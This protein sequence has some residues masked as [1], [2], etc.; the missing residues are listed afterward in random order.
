MQLNQILKQFNSN[1]QTCLFSATLP[2]ALAEFTRAGLKEPDLIR[3]DVDNKLSEH[4]Q[5]KF[6]NIRK[7]EKPAALLFLLQQVID[8]NKEQTIIFA[9]TKHHVEYLYQLLSKLHM[10]VTLIYGQL[11]AS[12]RKINIAKF[13]KKLCSILIVTDVA[14]R[15]IDIPLLDN[16]IHYD[17]PAKAKLF[18]HR[19][20]RV[21]RAGRAGISYSLIAND[22]LPYMLD[23]FLFLS[24]P[25]QNK[26]KKDLTYNEHK[27]QT[28]YGTIPRYILDINLDD[29]QAVHAQ[30]N[31][32]LKQYQTSLRAYKMY[33]K[34][35]S[36]ASRSSASR[37]KELSTDLIHPDFLYHSKYKLKGGQERL[38]LNLTGRNKMLKN[39]SQYD[40]KKT[41]FETLEKKLTQGNDIM[42]YKRLVHS[43]VI[44]QYD[45]DLQHQAQGAG[46]GNYLS[47]INQKL[48]NRFSTTDS[49]SKT[50]IHKKKLINKHIH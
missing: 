19:S 27:P 21:A 14:A 9:S 23:L 1:R 2:K 3:L 35:R 44:D 29:I 25:V 46:T 32:L 11:D 16:V 49:S 28:Y 40:G 47:Q 42:R 6:F 15:G 7:E 34:T 50:L 30:D 48:K 17:F 10:K 36:G 24:F 45:K 33:Y 5:C 8:I 26:V 43:H 12:A 37:A 31:I 38:Q 22:E 20:G 4:L 39:I 13:H 41:I 18:I